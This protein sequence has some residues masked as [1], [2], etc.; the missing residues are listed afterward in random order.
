MQSVIADTKRDVEG[1]QQAIDKMLI[2]DVDHRAIVRTYPP[3]RA[4]ASDGMSA[5]AK[6]DVVGLRRELQRWRRRH[7]RV[8][9]RD[10]QELTSARAHV[11]LREQAL[12]QRQSLLVEANAHAEH[13]HGQATQ[14]VEQIDSVE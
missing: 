12:E 8:C 11:V 5:S 14:L 2:E 10:I 6:R 4:E 13:L 3:G 9:C 1:I 7:E